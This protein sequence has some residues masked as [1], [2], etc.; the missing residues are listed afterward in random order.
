[1]RMYGLYGKKERE[2]RRWVPLSTLTFRKPAA[3]R[4]FQ[5]ALLAPFMSPVMPVYKVRELR[6]AKDSIDPVD[7]PADALS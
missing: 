3:V 4:I 7:V 5:D 1:M 2:D 6:V